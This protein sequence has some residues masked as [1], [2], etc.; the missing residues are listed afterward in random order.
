M[1]VMNLDLVVLSELFSCI[2]LVVTLTTFK[3]TAASVS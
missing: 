2:T 3:V 1:K